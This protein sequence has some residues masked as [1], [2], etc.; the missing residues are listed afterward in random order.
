MRPII[1]DSEHKREIAINRIN[2]LVLDKPWKVTIEPYR[3]KRSLDQN[4]LMWM[5]F[6]E[7][8]DEIGD[9]KQAV[10]DDVLPLLAEPTHQ[11]KGMPQ[12]ST[13]RMDTATMA[14][15]MNKL[16]EW[17]F[18]F[19]GIALPLPEEQQRTV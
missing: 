19:H 4:A 12:W 1:L 10:H 13:S 2:A 14:A 17:A 3:K 16:H 6:K 9:T 18:S 7:I 15:F 8:A 5:W 11:M